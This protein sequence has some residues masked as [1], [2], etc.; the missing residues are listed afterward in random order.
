MQWLRATSTSL[1]NV[2][3]LKH[4]ALRWNLKTNSLWVGRNQLHLGTTRC[5]CM[6]NGCNKSIRLLTTMNSIMTICNSLNS[7]NKLL[8]SMPNISKT[9]SWSSIIAM[10]APSICKFQTHVS[11]RT[12]TK[13]PSVIYSV[14]STVIVRATKNNP[15]QTSLTSSTG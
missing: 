11:R 1:T 9:I 12:K 6:T 4:I 13:K 15:T 2:T 10:P 14:A 7:I 8:I 3:T 5:S